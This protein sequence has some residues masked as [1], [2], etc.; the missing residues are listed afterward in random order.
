MK[1]SHFLTP[2]GLLSATLV[3]ALMSAGGAGHDARADNTSGSSANNM[4]LVGTN[5]LQSRSTYQPTVHRYPGDKYILF[6]GHHA[7]ATSPVTGQPLPSF[8]SL[9]GLYEPNGTSLVDVSNPKKPV[10]LA[11]IPV[12]PTSPSPPTAPIVNAGGAQ[13]VRVCDGN[14]LPIGNNKVYMLRSYANSAHEI[15]DVTDPK[16]PLPVR[17]VAGHNPVIGDT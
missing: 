14:T 10:L 6:A 12:G 1:R 4:R 17:T 13:M 15:W 5:D 2:S 16:K 3:L 11:H 8:N 7:L 9:T